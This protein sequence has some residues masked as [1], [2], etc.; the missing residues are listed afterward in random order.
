[1]TV[2]VALPRPAAVTLTVE[3]NPG[4][5]KV[6]DGKLKV[7]TFGKAFTVTE[8]VV[9]A[10]DVH[11]LLSVTVTLYIPAPA[12][13]MPVLEA[14][15]V[16]AVNPPGPL[17]A[18][19]VYVP[20]PPA[21]VAFKVAVPPA[22]NAVGVTVAVMVGNAFKVTEAVVPTDAAV[23]PLLSVTETLYT[24]VP[25]ADIPGCVVFCEVAV[26]PPGPDHIKEE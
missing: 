21:G 4:Q 24:P 6:D 17:H 7:L 18:Y 25:L 12:A 14:F 5:G 26:K 2:Y 1:M 19:D 15:C 11:P 20:L 8:P 10:G 23:Q 16:D 9:P 22:H 3:A 13:V